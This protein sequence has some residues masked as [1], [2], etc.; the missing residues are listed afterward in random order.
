MPEDEPEAGGT[1]TLCYIHALDDQ[2]AAHVRDV[3][4]VAQA[5]RS[6]TA[7]RPPEVA[8]LWAAEPGQVAKTSLT[9]T[10]QDLRTEE[11]PS[12]KTAR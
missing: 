10:E 6:E 7:R 1:S 2:V 4:P 11:T 5:G 3:A 8:R 9:T 12:W